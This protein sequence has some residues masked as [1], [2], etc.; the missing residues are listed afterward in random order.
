MKHKIISSIA[1]VIFAGALIV[2]GLFVPEKL[3][4]FRDGE[5]RGQINTEQIGD[6]DP[7]SVIKPEDDTE[8]INSPENTGDTTPFMA[9]EITTRLESWDNRTAYA[10]E[11]YSTELSIEQAS[12]SGIHEL[13]LMA[14]YMIDLNDSVADIDYDSFKFQSATLYAS[15]TN[16]ETARWSIIYVND[17]SSE[18]IIIKID[19]I[20]GQIYY[21]DICAN[22]VGGIDFYHGDDTMNIASAFCNYLGFDNELVSRSDESFA[23]NSEHLVISVQSTPTLSF[24]I[25]AMR[26]EIFSE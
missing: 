3:L 26:I 8:H 19:A 15:I 12:F 7:I 6:K 9:N 20:S 17:D 13:K 23:I 2:A 24:S 5:L 10:R 14:N 16:D 25:P 11:P 22:A 1:A 21:V 4:E 18:K